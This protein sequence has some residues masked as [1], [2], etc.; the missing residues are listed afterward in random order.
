MDRGAW[1]A[2]V[3]EVIKESDMTQRINNNNPCI[4]YIYI[5]IYILKL[6]TNIPEICLLMVHLVYE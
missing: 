4:L 6:N 3:H 1:Q 2:T 5:Y